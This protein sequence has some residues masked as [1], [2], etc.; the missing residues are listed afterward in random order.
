LD[1]FNSRGL[2]TGA[3]LHPESGLL[4]LVGYTN[5]TWKPFAWIIDS[6]QGDNFFT[7]NMLRV[8]L[9]KLITNQIE[10]VVFESPTRV[11]I[12]SETSKTAHARAF[13]LDVGALLL[14][15]AI[16]SDARMVTCNKTMR[17]NKTETGF[18]LAFRK[19]QKFPVEV[20]YEGQNQEVLKQTTER[21]CHN[22]KRIILPMADIPDAA[23]TLLIRTQ[24]LQTRCLLK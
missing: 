5:K 17:L 12:T 21:L 10:G 14:K 23:A 6:Y 8:A 20:I 4:V 24:N 22:Q 7:S 11:I 2:I 15:T 19:R 3:D 9:K 13:T 1:S 18:E 16:A